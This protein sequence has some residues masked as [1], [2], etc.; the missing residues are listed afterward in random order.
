MA[1][2][3]ILTQQTLADIINAVVPGTYTPSIPRKCMSYDEVVNV[4]NAISSTV[5]LTISPFI[6]N[7]GSTS[8]YASRQL[9][10]KVTITAQEVIT[11]Y[12]Y[13]VSSKAHGATVI[14]AS[15]HP[16]EDTV[17]PGEGNTY[18]DDNTLESVTFT[19]DLN[20]T[21]LATIKENNNFEWPSKT[22]L[23]QHYNNYGATIVNRQ[24]TFNDVISIPANKSVTLQIVA[25]YSNNSDSPHY[26]LRDN[27]LYLYSV[28]KIRTLKDTSKQVSAGQ[29]VIITPEYDDEIYTEELIPEKITNYTTQYVWPDGDITNYDDEEIILPSTVTIYE[30]TVMVLG[31]VVSLPVISNIQEGEFALHRLSVF[32]KNNLYPEESGKIFVETMD[33][34]DVWIQ[35][36]NSSSKKKIYFTVNVNISS[37]SILPILQVTFNEDVGPTVPQMFV[38]GKVVTALGSFPFTITPTD[39]TLINGEYIGNFDSVSPNYGEIDTTDQITDLVLSNFG[40]DDWEYVLSVGNITGH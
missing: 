20:G 18:S 16:T 4:K 37:S 14:I 7:D 1:T 13:T 23:F 21:Y 30:A 9:V 22:G 33:K 40:D 26:E 15:V 19:S 35:R 27:V 12:N 8:S 17:I 34:L 38:T 36:I 11:N 28:P 29:N 31:I 2:Y 3:E 32:F 24:A 10:Q 25:S 39:N 6:K 5:A